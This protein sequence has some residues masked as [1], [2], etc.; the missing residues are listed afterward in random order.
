MGTVPPEGCLTACLAHLRKRSSLAQLNECS[1]NNLLRRVA[2]GVGERTPGRP[3]WHSACCSG[4]AQWRCAHPATSSC[5]VSQTGSTLRLP[6]PQDTAAQRAAAKQTALLFASHA[7]ALRARCQNNPRQQHVN[8]LFH[9]RNPNPSSQTL[10]CVTANVEQTNDD[11]HAQANT[12]ANATRTRTH[13]HAN[14]IW[15]SIANVTKILKIVDANHAGG[16][17]LLTPL[18]V[19]IDGRAREGPVLHAP[20]AKRGPSH[21]RPF[22]EY[23]KVL[24]GREREGPCS[25]SAAPACSGRCP[26]D[27]SATAPL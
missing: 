9:D 14:N 24:K 11:M 19:L 16:P 22:G 3:H 20:H 1:Q 17:V 5:Q 27:R 25:R 23:N 2:A 10:K 7:A 12:F 26:G 15:K 8:R 4:W 13:E 6:A 18:H 21:G